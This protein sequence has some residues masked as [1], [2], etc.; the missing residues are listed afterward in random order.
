MRTL[1]LFA[2][3]VLLLAACAGTSAYGVSSPAKIAGGEFKFEH[4]VT[5]R[6]LGRSWAVLADRAHPERPWIEV[7]LD[8]PGTVVRPE[9]SA[10]AF[11]SSP[12]SG[13]AGKMTLAAA[14]F[15]NA[16]APVA[17]PRIVL[18]GTRVTVW[19]AT[20]DA[21]IEL[22]GTATDSAALGGVVHVRTAPGRALLTGIVRGPGSVELT[23]LA[24]QQWSQP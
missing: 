11:P 17:A 18:P 16:P 2:G 23:G 19:Q 7:P 14:Q 6:A 9:E 10:K 21:R 1:S 22:S 24:R 13:I 15:H 20:G 3:P 4:Y 12:Q 8:T 5:D